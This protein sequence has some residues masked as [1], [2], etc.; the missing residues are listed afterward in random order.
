M[1]VRIIRNMYENSWYKDKFGE[2]F[3]VSSTAVGYKVKSGKYKG[4]HIVGSDVCRVYDKYKIEITSC[5][6]NLF[7][8]NNLI[9]K[10]FDVVDKYDN[11]EFNVTTDLDKYSIISAT[12]L[13]KDCKILSKLNL[14]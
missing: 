6:N 10:I 12:I 2:I 4:L 7:W 14:N 9:G 13:K 1:K 5:C 11:D 8:Y 3:D